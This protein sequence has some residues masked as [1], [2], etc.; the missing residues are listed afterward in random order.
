MARPRLGSRLRRL[1]SRALGSRKPQ[2]ERS[3]EPAHPQAAPS[4]LEGLPPLQRGRGETPGPNHK[5]DISQEW[6]SAQ[7]HSG[8]PPSFVD[9]REAP[10]F[11]AGHIPGA[12]SAPGWTLRERLDSL[13]DRD[14]RLAI[15]DQDGEGESAAVAAWLREQGWK[16]ARRLQDGFEGWIA[17]GD[18]VETS[19]QESDDGS[20]RSDTPTG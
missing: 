14:E 8:V 6:A 11:A 4:S 15:Y 19:Q 17:A 18:S 3:T 20:P 1:A 2:P 10:H 7:L 9:L 5:L 13:P 16:G 12:M